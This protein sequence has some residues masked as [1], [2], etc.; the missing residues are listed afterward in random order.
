MNDDILKR[1]GDHRDQTT[2][3][4]IIPS[5]TWV[6][7]AFPEFIRLPKPGKRCFW[8]GLTRSAMNELVLGENPKVASMVLTREGARRGV[9]LVSLSAL[10]AFLRGEMKAQQS[11]GLPQGKEASH[12]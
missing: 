1:S 6:N 12:E 3:Q 11:G 7:K 4:E 2:S 10:L 8:T 5:A 9:R